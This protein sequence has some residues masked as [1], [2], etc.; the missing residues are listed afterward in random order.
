MDEQEVVYSRMGSIFNLEER[1]S[2]Y[3][4]NF[5]IQ[6]ETNILFENISSFVEEDFK[7]SEKMKF[8]I[9]RRENLL[10]QGKVFYT[11]SIICNS[12]KKYP[13]YD[14]SGGKKSIFY[15]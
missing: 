2:S 14:Y 5:Y 12:I 3:I 6:E 15:D 11:N 9:F 13:L 10:P 4:A 1:N 7:D 8:N